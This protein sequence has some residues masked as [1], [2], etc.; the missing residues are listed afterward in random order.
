MA[1]DVQEFIQQQKLDKCV[2]IGHSMYVVIFPMSSAAQTR[3]SSV[4]RALLIL[5]ISKGVPKLQW[6]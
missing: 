1:E 3:G 6:Q 5:I 4:L 2:L